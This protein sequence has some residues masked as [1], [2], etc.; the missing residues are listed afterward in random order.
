MSKV[1]LSEENAKIKQK[2]SWD[3]KDSKIKMPNPDRDIVNLIAEMVAEGLQLSQE[4]K[5]GEDN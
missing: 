2:L 5:E 4:N 3:F 1:Q